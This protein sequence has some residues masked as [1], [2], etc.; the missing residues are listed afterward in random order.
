MIYSVTG[1]PSMIDENTLAISS[2]AVAYEVIA[3]TNTVYT[4]G[5]KNSDVTVLTYL[6]VREDDMK[7]FGFLDKTEKALFMHL[8]SVSG[9]GPKM[10]I[11]IL[12]GITSQNLAVAIST[13]DVKLL[14]G[15]K[16]LGKKTAE[17]IVLELKD[18]LGELGGGLGQVG[19]G[20]A[21]I[22]ATLSSPAMV[23]ALETLILLG[24]KRPE[25]EA[26]IK[27]VAKDGMTAEDIV[28]KALSKV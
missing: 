1:K 6:Y 7:L 5:S 26:A 23:D 13:G 28:K 14:S 17:R 2:G 21:S 11:S 18:K 15:I 20:A 22:G 19:G 4:L 27:Q 24:L 12:S 25:A 10:A 8:I 9:I 16:G 3:S